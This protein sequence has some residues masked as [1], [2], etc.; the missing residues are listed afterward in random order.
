MPPQTEKQRLDHL[1]TLRIKAKELGL[2]YKLDGATF[3]HTDIPH[4]L[5]DFSATDP[6]KL[7]LSIYQQ[8]KTEFSSWE[9]KIPLDN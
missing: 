5:F 7:M 8:L 9:L 1:H 4:F 2:C 6:N 3:Y